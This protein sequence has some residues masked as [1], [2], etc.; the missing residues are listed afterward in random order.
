M[1]EQNNNLGKKIIFLYPHSVIQK[2]LIKEIIKYEY[3]VYVFNDHEKVL[4]ILDK[5]TDSILF[6]NIDSNLKESEWEIYIR[7]IM[8]NPKT[9][10]VKT[11]ILSYNENQALIE[12]YVMGM[13]VA[14]GYIVL[15][16]GLNESLKIIL[17]VLEAS[18]AK[19]RRQFVRAKCTN[20][21]NI[22][23][24]VK[25]SD[26]VLTGNIYDISS[27][28]MACTFNESYLKEIPVNSYFQDIQLRLKGTLIMLSGKVVGVRKQEEDYYII[29]FDNI[30]KDE[31]KRNKIQTFIHNY[32]QEELANEFK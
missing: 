13:S 12:K 2:D 27:I 14:C 23:F 4:K 25:V 24:N 16:I 3:E 1:S 11:G 5:Y 20:K 19:G 18:E 17:K 30:F 26:K 31:M 10:D 15:K 8:Q 6:I 9:A 29:M 22:T 7:H 32:L 28:G 21:T